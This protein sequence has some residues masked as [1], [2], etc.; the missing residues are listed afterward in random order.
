MEHVWQ[1]SQL[2]SRRWCSAPTWITIF[3]HYCSG[4]FFLKIYHSKRRLS[5]IGFGPGGWKSIK[6]IDEFGHQQFG[7]NC[8]AFCMHLAPEAIRCLGDIL[9]ELSLFKNPSTRHFLLLLCTVLERLEILLSELDERPFTAA[10]ALSRI[11]TETS[12]I[13][14]LTLVYVFWNA[15]QYLGRLFFRNQSNWLRSL[16]YYIKFG[17]KG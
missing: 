8:Q 16:V 7:W 9:E 15:T 4:K 5:K 2:R 10:V 6:A 14:L 12:L 3:E 17:R 11:R 1:W 13:S